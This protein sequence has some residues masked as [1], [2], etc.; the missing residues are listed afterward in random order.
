MVNLSFLG[1]MRRYELTK[2]ENERF[3]V[4]VIREIDPQDIGGASYDE[5]Y[6]LAYVTEDR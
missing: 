3:E 4:K 2:Q 1:Q 6:A 5:V